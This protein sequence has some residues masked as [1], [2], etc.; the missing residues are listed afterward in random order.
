MRIAVSGGGYRTAA[1]P[2]TTG[3]QLAAPAGS[4]LAGEIDAVLSDIAPDSD[5]GSYP[6]REGVTEVAGPATVGSSAWLQEVKRR[7]EERLS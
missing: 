5:M 6:P 2:F 3:N 1:D 7:V 4:G